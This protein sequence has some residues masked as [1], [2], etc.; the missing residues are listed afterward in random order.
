VILKEK[1]N[2]MNRAKNSLTKVKRAAIQMKA[3]DAA[4]VAEGSAK[5]IVCGSSN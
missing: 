3:G 2:G 1:L 4:T 5:K